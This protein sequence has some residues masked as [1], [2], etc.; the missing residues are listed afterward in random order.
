MP[1][2]SDDVDVRVDCF[3]KAPEIVENLRS[4]HGLRCKEEALGTGDYLVGEEIL[5]ERKR[6]KDFEQSMISGRLFEQ[7][8]R[9]AASRYRPLMLL[10]DV[11]GWTSVSTNA[12]QGA[13]LSLILEFGVPVIHSSSKRESAFLLAD[14][15]RRLKK[16]S[17]ASV[18]LGY[19]PRRLRN[20]ALFVITSLPGIG[21][22]VGE[23]ALNYFGSLRSA[24]GTDE[25]SWRAVP[26][27]GKNKASHIRALLDAKFEGGEGVPGKSRPR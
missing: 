16:G 23:N 11:P 21:R 5:V 10:E 17:S 26:G 14:I 3:E 12:L 9:L 7:A 4:D 22:T 19:R 13:V 25:K 15:H 27:I 18:R 8:Q 24:F 1:R 2:S 20:R 6:G